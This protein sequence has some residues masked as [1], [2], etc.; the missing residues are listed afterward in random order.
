MPEVSRETH[1]ISLMSQ[2]VQGPQHVL[3]EDQIPHDPGIVERRREPEFVSIERTGVVLVDEEPI[4]VG[5][6]G[7][8]SNRGIG[9]VSH[10]GGALAIRV[11]DFRNGIGHG[12][13]GNTTPEPQI[14]KSVGKLVFGR[15][16]RRARILSDGPGGFLRRLPVRM[17]DNRP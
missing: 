9:G 10:A 2:F 12:S 13:S 14:R 17:S 5:M 8:L 6:D 16:V 3:N 11:I 1:L 4:L 15:A 7:S